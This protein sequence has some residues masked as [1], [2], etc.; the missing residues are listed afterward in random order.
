MDLRT[1]LNERDLD[2]DP[3]RQFTHWLSEATRAGVPMANAMALATVSADGVPSVRMVLLPLVDER[4][5]VFET[6]LESPK[7]KDL[8]AVPRA[9]LAFYWAPLHRQV[10]VS[11]RVEPIPVG[12]AQGYFAGEPPEIQAMIR[13]CPQSQVI[14]DRAALEQLYAAALAAP[15]TAL[16]AYWGGY[17]LRP[18]FIEFWQG[19][20]NRLQDRL[21]FTR[22]ASNGWRIERLVP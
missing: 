17:R 16:P 10:R 3:I 21:R 8:A 20:P 11:G 7:A 4:G 22:D 2:S 13:A 19:R 6:N 9:A 15:D 12:E 18:E 14:A 5:F 1:E